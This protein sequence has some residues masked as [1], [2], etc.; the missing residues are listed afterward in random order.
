MKIRS[1]VR[2]SESGYGVLQQG[3]AL[4]F[5]LKADK[6][7][8]KSGGRSEVASDQVASGYASFF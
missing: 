3:N 7:T 6:T 4:L 5:Q 1:D 2:P 8:Q